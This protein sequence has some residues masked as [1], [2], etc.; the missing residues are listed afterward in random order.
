MNTLLD[1]LRTLIIDGDLKPNDVLLLSLVA[2]RLEHLEATSP[3]AQV[4]RLGERIEAL[5][6]ELKVA[7]D[8]RAEAVRGAE[9]E[10]V[11]AGLL[12]KGERLRH[13]VKDTRKGEWPEEEQALLYWNGYGW[14]S[15]AHTSD[16]EPFA[17]DLWLPA[18]PPPTDG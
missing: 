13:N 7:N 1:R 11:A 6:A 12:L 8:C 3:V 5:E 16:D 9:V 14:V 17:G 10:R 15:W 2:G 18:P 4:A